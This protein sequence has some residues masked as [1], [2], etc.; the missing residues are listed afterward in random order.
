MG[1]TSEQTSPGGA[2]AEENVVSAVERAL[3]NSALDFYGAAIAVIDYRGRDRPRLRWDPRALDAV[4][5]AMGALERR[6]GIAY[7]AG[8]STDRIVSITRLE[9]DVV[10][11][12]VDR[13]R[14]QQER[15]HVQEE[16]G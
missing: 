6:I 5:L 8:Y 16:A 4:R 11:L 7:R 2:V 12:I 10:E 14:R 3:F 1:S 13:V 9:R 15:E